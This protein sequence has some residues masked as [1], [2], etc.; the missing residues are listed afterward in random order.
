MHGVSLKRALPL[1]GSL[2]ID[3]I[4]VEDVV[5][6]VTSLHAAGAKRESIRKTITYTAAVLTEHGI[7]PNPARDRRVRLPQEE[8][9]ELVPPEAE[10]VE[11]VYATLPQAHRLAL[12]WLDWSGARVSSVDLLL[13]SDYDEPRGRVRLRKEITENAARALGRSASRARS[14]LSDSLG[15]REDRNP[16]ARIFAAS[17][18]DALRTSIGKACRAARHPALLAARPA[19]PAHQR[20]A[21]AGQDVRRD[22]RLR[23]AAQALDHE[24]HLHPCTH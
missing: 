10:H 16:D 18:A 20:P 13:V 12:L 14:A 6:L 22:R 7:E 4:T 17:G 3:A 21:S 8:E 19:P 2:R 11:A 15:P 1:L 5:G 9:R 24:R 23:R